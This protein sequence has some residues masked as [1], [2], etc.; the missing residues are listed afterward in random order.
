MLSL[1]A[2][3]KSLATI[4]QYGIGLRLFIRW[5][6]QNGH[7]PDISRTLVRLF[8]DHLLATGSSP[9]TAQLR[10]QALKRFAAWLVDEG[11]VDENPLLGMKPPKVDVKIV[12]NLTD[13]DLRL[14]LRA[15]QGPSF[16]DRRDE[17]VVRLLIE[18]GMRAGELLNL[19][20]D[21]VDLRRGLVAIH[22][23]KTGRG[24][25][26]PFGPQTGQ[27]LDRYLRLRRR[28]RLA[29]TTTLWLGDNSRGTIAYHGMRDAILNRAE[30]AGLRNFRLHRLRHTAASRWLRE[31]GSENGALAVLGWSSRQMLDRY[32][33][34]T[35]S[36]RAADEARSLNLG[37][38]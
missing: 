5:C 2:E 32:V 26:V 4:E 6:D 7:S 11:E 3:R 19:T 35:A 10:L 27:A 21:D 33:A 14:L 30:S 37:D 24:R 16:R 23:S 9:S 36:E 28:H 34:A 29:H 12:D 22:R 20:V 38:L 17:A 25:V 13:D 1:R 31:G 8:I 18:T 15:C